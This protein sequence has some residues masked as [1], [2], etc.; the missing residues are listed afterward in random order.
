MTL[1][2]GVRSVAA[3]LMVVAALGLGA[4]PALAG[5]APFTYPGS[6]AMDGG[7]PGNQGSGNNIGGTGMLYS[8][9][10][11]HYGTDVPDLF[12]GAPKLV[13]GESLERTIWLRNANAMAVEVSIVP[14][15]PSS[16][17]QVDVNAGSSKV[18]ALEPG[19][20]ASVRIGA[21]L[22]EDAGNGSQSRQD[23]VTLRVVVAEA[24]PGSPG[25]P[26]KPVGPGGPGLPGWPVR[27]GELGDT[28]AALGMWPLAV[29]ALVGGA[30]A[31][32]SRRRTSRAG[33]AGDNTCTE[34]QQ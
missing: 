32:A 21:R 34:G 17:V 10:G 28:G 33:K 14:P 5:P 18:V 1:C 9:D 27:P 8:G 31:L 22:P 19:G 24:R 16:G 2:N 20:S 15:V 3:G 7:E 25:N 13:P 6:L 4:A 30:A 23:A 12:A 11:V 26:G 29:A